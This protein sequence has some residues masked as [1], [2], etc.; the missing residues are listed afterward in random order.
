MRYRLIFFTGLGIGF[1]LGAR[2]GRERYE[3]LRK[4]A[5]K[6]ADSP[7]VQQAA[8]AL[9]AQAASYAKSAGGKVAGRAGAARAKVGG[10]LH[11]HVPG[12][13]VRES[14]GHP[15]DGGGAHFVQAPGTAGGPPEG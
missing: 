2:A 15:A 11:D 7:A 8:G 10:A 6:A 3:Q 13:R 4:L 14:N 1:V 12:M 9:Q 5:R